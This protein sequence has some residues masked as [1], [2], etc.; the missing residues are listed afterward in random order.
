MTDSTTE[1]VENDGIDFN[2]EDVAL[3]LLSIRRDSNKVANLVGDLD[4]SKIADEEFDPKTVDFKAIR[5]DAGRLSRAANSLYVLFKTDEDETEEKAE[6]KSAPESAPAKPA[7]A[8][9]AKSAAKSK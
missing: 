7:A 8:S 5:R 4:L 3:K 2:P 1:V 9:K 6:A